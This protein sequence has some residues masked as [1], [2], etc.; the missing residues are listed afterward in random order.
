MQSSH[1]GATTGGGRVFPLRARV[2]ASAPPLW[3]DPPVALVPARRPPCRPRLGSSAVSRSCLMV[4][5]RELAS[6]PAL[7]LEAPTQVSADEARARDRALDEF[8]SWLRQLCPVDQPLIAAGLVSGAVAPPPARD[9]LR[10]LKSFAQSQYDVGKASWRFKTLLLAVQDRAPELRGGP[11]RPAWKALTRW[12]KSE[13]RAPTLPLPFACFAAMFAAATALG[14]YDFAIVLLLSWHAALRPGEML[15]ARRAH[16]SLPTDR[17]DAR[18][19]IFV[20]I[21]EHKTSAHAGIGLQH[22][23]IREPAA[24]W[25]LT[26]ALAERRP[27]DR[28]F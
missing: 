5:R 20:A 9:T 26:R 7:D 25:F 1:A 14:Q 11:L 12:Q 15:A 10:F 23:A 24:V 4:R 21:P 2:L 27:A 17:L 28:I 19:V 16:L 22:A 18:P 6:R 8:L 3:D 13:A